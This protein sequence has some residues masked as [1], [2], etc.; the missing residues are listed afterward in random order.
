VA[1]LGCIE[2]TI[3]P[4]AT[5]H[6]APM[7]ALIEALIAAGHAYAAQGHVLFDVSRSPITASWPTE[8]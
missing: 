8:A 3:T 7:I 1:A 4:R 6:I 5:E 2:P